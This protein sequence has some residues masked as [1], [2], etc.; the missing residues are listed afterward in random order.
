MLLTYYYILKRKQKKSRNK[1]NKNLK[2]QIQCNIE[3]KEKK[4]Y[5]FS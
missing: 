2:K 1:T 4:R 3:R 5:A